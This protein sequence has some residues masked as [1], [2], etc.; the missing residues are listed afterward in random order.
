MTAE[1]R[2]RKY[3][4]ILQLTEAH[5]DELLRRRIAR[6]DAADRR[7]ALRLDR[8]EALAQAAREHRT[9]PWGSIGAARAYEEEVERLTY[10][11][12]EGEE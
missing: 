9:T 10:A 12:E 8:I 4:R 1:L 11:E 5:L 2:L 7:A 3:T 6:Q